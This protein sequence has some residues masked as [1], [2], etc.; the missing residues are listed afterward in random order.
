MSAHF[1]SK[2]FY[3]NILH[4]IPCRR[5]LLKLN[6]IDMPFDAVSGNI[7]SDNDKVC[8]FVGRFKRIELKIGRAMPTAIRCPLTERVRCGNI[9]KR[10]GL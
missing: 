1:D 3:G 4:I 5:L 10:T 2:V 9:I 8:R 7:I 6:I